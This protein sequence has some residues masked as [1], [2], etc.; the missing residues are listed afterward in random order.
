MA[1][2]ECLL[3][4]VTYDYCP[5]CEKDRNKPRWMVMLHDENCHN[6]FD[7]LQQ[8]YTHKDSDE[9]TIAKLKACDLS[10]LEKS[11]EAVKNQ[12]KEIFAKEIKEEN[13][14]EE[15]VKN[16][17]VVT[18]KESVQIQQNATV[19]KKNKKRIVKEN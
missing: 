12:V 8:N 3:C 14:Q 7:A 2:R 1:K 4:H 9:V 16:T 18:S 15:P 11:T 5:Y 10:V 13:K 6:I 19:V 17:E